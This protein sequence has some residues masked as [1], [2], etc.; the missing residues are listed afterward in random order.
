MKLK[1]VLAMALAV[2]M[3]LA[4]PGCGSSE[5]AK[6]GG[7]KEA[8]GS[9]EFWNDKYAQKD[10]SDIDKMIESIEGLSNTDMEVVAYPDTASYQ[11]AM[12]QSIKGEDAPGLFTWWS[13]PQLET[14]AKNG[15]VEDLTDIWD[16][17]IEANG[18]SPDIADAL[19]VDGK[20][21]A[22]P[23]SVIYN[24][25]IYNTHVL[26]DNSLEVPETF[27]EFLDLCET[28]KSKGITPIGL[29]NDSWAGFIWFQQLLAAKNPQLYLDVCNGTKPYTDPEV[30]EVMNIWKDML[31]KGYFTAPMTIMDM[32]KELATGKTAMFLEPNYEAVNLEKEF[33]VKC[34][35]DIST[36]V[37]P[38]MTDDVKKVVFFEVAPLCVSTNSKD[39]DA[40]MEVMKKW[41]TKEHQTVLTETD[42][43]VN[44]SE[45]E[46]NNAVVNKM[47]EYSQDTENYSMILRYYEN[48]PSEIRDIALDQFMKF[49][50]GN[51]DV[52]EV[53]N[54]I[55]E[56]ADE[57][58]AK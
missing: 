38:T 44:T 10:Q 19:S 39:K 28:L 18:V 40:A 5:E 31:D 22:A 6:E 27:D 30:I 45:V 9:L 47:I 37:L 53:V 3:I 33:D 51:A 14:L 36:F 1:K 42:G 26:E 55:Q 20:I 43:N 25:V 15:L 32:K 12:Q 56:K 11:T 41:F 23:Y 35:E 24:A 4:V 52:D 29:K 57:I 21:V 2:S 54:T 49:Q 58:F 50:M 48:T 16:E 7:D 34:G 13:G 8:T 46:V 17:Y